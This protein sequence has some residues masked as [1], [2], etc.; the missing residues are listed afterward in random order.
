MSISYGSMP[1][2]VATVSQYWCNNF[3]C[4]KLF[5]L[6]TSVGI[7]V[8]SKVVIAV[9]A[10]N[11]DVAVA[12]AG[13]NSGVVTGKRFLC[14]VQDE[15]TITKKQTNPAIILDNMAHLTW[16]FTRT[17]MTLYDNSMGCFSSTPIL[18]KIS[19]SH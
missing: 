18:L 8:G 16:F 9:G 1:V 13:V 7:G 2:A 19:N 3:T 4:F 15:E 12:I 11:V 6:M 10:S 17:Q 14:D 5:G